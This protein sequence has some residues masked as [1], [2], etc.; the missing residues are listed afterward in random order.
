MLSLVFHDLKKMTS[1]LFTENSFDRFLLKSAS[2]SAMLS[3]TISGEKDPDFFS[4]EEREK[5]MQESFVRY[6]TVRPLLFS[7]IKG[8][9]PPLSFRIILITDKNTTNSLKVKS[10]FSGAEVTSLSM[11]F[12]FKNGVLT[13]SSGV[14]YSG[15]TLDKSLEALWDQTIRNF[16]DQKDVTYE[17]L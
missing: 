5:E 1:L 9:R 6:E 7:L 2:L 17:A 8:K 16:L 14:S 11:N 12:S 15:F 3:V 13:L 10:G 4:E